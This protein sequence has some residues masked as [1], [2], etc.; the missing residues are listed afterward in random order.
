MLRRPAVHFAAPNQWINDPNG[1]IFVDGE[2]HLF[3]QLNPF[4][5]TWGHMSW[6]HAVS[7]DLVHWTPL[8]TA[9]TPYPARQ[10]DAATLI[11][12][13][14]V[15]AASDGQTLL[16]YYTA[17]ECHGDESLNESVALA[18]STD[19]GRTWQR[20]ADNPILD[21]GRI[22]F[23]D[24]KVIRF[25]DDYVMAIAVPTERTIEFYRSSDG[26]SWTR[27]GAFNAPTPTRRV[28]ECPDLFRVP[29]A[30]PA[31]A[32]AQDWRWVLL[33][34]A[35]HPAGGEYTGMQYW[36]GEFDG[37]T[38][39]PD[40]SEPDW[41]EYGRD[42]YAGVTFNGLDGQRPVL[43]GWASNWAYA[44]QLPAVPWRGMMAIP[45]ALE[46]KWFD[47]RLRLVQRPVDL[48]GQAPIDIDGSVDV[49]RNEP[50][51]ID[52][53]WPCGSLHIRIDPVRR[54][55]SV[56]RTGA[57]LAD[58]AL[59]AGVDLAPIFGS[60]P[61]SVRM[62]CDA[63]LVELFVNDGS[64]VLTTLV[65]PDGDVDVQTCGLTEQ[66]RLERRAP[67]P[68]LGRAGEHRPHRAPHR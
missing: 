11:F 6:G 7:T 31:S 2:Y 8:D 21:T 34:S 32:G 35:G 20:W 5:P 27:T 65:F 26:L 37:A 62:I 28:W 64:T 4:G 18:T 41:V 33:V 52:L 40:R 13:G 22:D 56:D 1:L 48:L 42:F 29:V 47:D 57:G 17:H 63:G 53:S 9:L 67:T 61:V 44:S 38:F 30:A 3:F 45:R 54:Q 23:R 25:G 66:R 46:L 36:I 43:V 49:E 12:S 14:S 39:H 24:P 15:V 59:Y 68:E 19:R 51:R 50:A 10:P 55:V 58:V 60:G 16:A